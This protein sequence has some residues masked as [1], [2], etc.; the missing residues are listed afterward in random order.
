MKRLH[1]LLIIVLALT[2]AA[3]AI[4]GMLWI[5]G[6]KEK[7]PAGTEAAGLPLGGLPRDEALQLLQT[8]RQALDSRVVTLADGTPSASFGADKPASGTEASGSSTRSAATDAASADEDEAGAQSPAAG[9][10]GTGG[11]DTARTGTGDSGAE[12]RRGWTLAELGLRLDPSGAEAALRRLG[13]GSVW[14]RAKYR[15]RWERQ[16]PARLRDDRQ[17]FDAAIR[18]EWGFYDERKPVDAVRTITPYDQVVY[19]PGRSVMH[20]DLDRQHAEL[21]RWA[22][23]GLGPAEP[24][25]PRSGARLRGLDGPA[26]LQ[27]LGLEASRET[28]LLLRSVAPAKTVE[29]LKAEGVERRIASFSTDYRTSSQGR[30][31]NVSETARTLDGWEM[32]PGEVFDYG[33]IIRITE[34]ETGYREAP[35]ILNGQFTRGIGG[36]ICQV[37]STLYNAALRAGLE[38]VERRNHSVPVSYLPKGQDA[39]FAEGVINFRFRNTTGKHLVIRASSGGGQLTIKLF[40]TMPREVRYAVASK[41][42][43]TMPAPVQLRRSGG[44]APGQQIVQK[45]GRTGYIVETYR[46]KYVNGQEVSRVRLSRDT[47]KPQPAVILEGPAAA[48]APPPAPEAGPE[49]AREAGPASGAPTPGGSSAPPPTPAEG[50]GALAAPDGGDSGSNSRDDA[51]S[52]GRDGGSPSGLLEDGLRVLRPEALLPG[53]TEEPVG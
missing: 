33:E 43:R 38:I 39:T 4:W 11:A 21:L 30:A 6:S 19:T 34:R 15:W 25:P 48:P 40:G 20:L 2:L 12:R 36:G 41:T 7:V 29:S 52:G 42:V 27:E 17:A 45:K 23:A 18:S 46:I 8:Y 5:Y 35:V 3:S 53:R 31:F 32:K 9:D 26:L 44:L 22:S 14:E 50:R 24:G 37:S 51:G 10:A 28:P 16:L 47:Y 13:T 1:L 49:G